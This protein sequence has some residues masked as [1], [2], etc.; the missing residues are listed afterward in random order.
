MD[1]FFYK[2][3]TVLV[4]VSVKN[5]LA[6]PV[7]F[8]VSGLGT[9]SLAEKCVVNLPVLMMV[10]QKKVAKSAYTI[11]CEGFYT[12]YIT[13]DRTLKYKADNCS[14]GTMAETRLTNMVATNMTGSSKRKLP[15]GVGRDLV[16]FYKIIYMS[17]YN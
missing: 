8:N 7:L 3:Q 10:L 12:G 15:K 2:K 6:L 4:G 13:P 1:Q 16:G 17:V 9:V 5:S 14:S 11:L